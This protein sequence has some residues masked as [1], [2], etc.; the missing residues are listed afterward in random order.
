[1]WHVD[2][3]FGVQSSKFVLTSV[4]VDTGLKSLIFDGSYNRSYC[5]FVLSGF[6][7]SHALNDFE[8]LYRHFLNFSP[9]LNKRSN[10]DNV[11][12]VESGKSVFHGN[13]SV[14]YVFYFGEQQR[15]FDFKQ[16]VNHPLTSGY[17]VDPIKI[18]KIP[19]AMLTD[20]ADV[21]LKFEFVLNYFESNTLCCESEV[22]KV[23]SEFVK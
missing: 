10:V 3:E 1:M 2:F 5:K 19:V 11:L 20:T 9:S 23:R 22:M 18:Y 17:N 16:S 14:K 4:H 15:S 13:S 6:Y 21:K 8:V 7:A 12:F